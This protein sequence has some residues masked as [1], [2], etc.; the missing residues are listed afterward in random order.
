M[1]SVSLLDDIDQLGED[2]DKLVEASQAPYLF[3]TSSWIKTWWG[4]FHGSAQ[5]YVVTIVSQNALIAGVPLMRKDGVISFIGGDDLFDYHDFVISAEDKAK[6]YKLF[7]SFLL[8]E[9]WEALDFTSIPESSPTIKYLPEFFETNGFK[10]QI[11]EEDVVPGLVLPETWDSFLQS[12]RKKDRHELRRKIRR[13]EDSSEYRLRSANSV[14]LDEDTSTLLDLMRTSH[15]GKND[16]LTENRIDFF[17][18]IIKEM[19][20]LNY[21]RL[22]FLE[23]EGTPVAGVLGFDYG[24][25]RWLY[26]SG[27]SLRSDSLS[28]GLVLKARFINEAIDL[29]LKYFDFMKGSEAYK[30][31]LGGKDS[32]LYRILVC[33]R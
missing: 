31:R 28:T 9:H 21:L 18:T 32:R 16:F 13:I 22:Q 26:N 23:M 11:L 5:P 2:W 20:E 4:M 15:L 3:V 24:G 12:L 30:Y 33:R 7:G 19:A 1:V 14:T 29:G 27:Y 8:E 25:V 17:R 10:V 6:C